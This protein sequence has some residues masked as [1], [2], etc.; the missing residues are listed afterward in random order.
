M[1]FEKDLTTAQVISG[2]NFKSATNHD[3][4]WEN[5]TSHP[6]HPLDPVKLPGKIQLGDLLKD[7]ID[8][9]ECLEKR[10]RKTIKQYQ[11][12]NRKTSKDDVGVIEK[13]VQDWMVSYPE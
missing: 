5:D 3:Q 6:F 4:F 1:I 7:S 11:K 13:D 9:K 10:Y 2:T 8:R 12:K